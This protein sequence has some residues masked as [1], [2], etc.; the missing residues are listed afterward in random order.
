MRAFFSNAPAHRRDTLQRVQRI[1]QRLPSLRTELRVQFKQRPF[2][3]HGAVRR[4]VRLVRKARPACRWQSG[5]IARA[6]ECNPLCFPFLIRNDK[7]I[8][9]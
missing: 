4:E 2:R 1:A 6:T 7:S 8:K 3:L 9:P 5:Q